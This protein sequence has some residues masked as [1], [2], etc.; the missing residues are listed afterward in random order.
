MSTEMKK[1]AILNIEKKV[2]HLYAEVQIDSQKEVIQTEVSDNLIDSLVYDRID[3]YV[4]GFIYFAMVNGYDIKSDL[5]ITDELLYN[6]NYQFIPAMCAAN[7]GWHIVKIDAPVVE[8]IA[9]V[10]HRVATGISCG[11]DSLYTIKFHESVR[12][13]SS[14]RIDSL[15]FFNVGSSMKSSDVLRTPLVEGRMKLAKKFALEY[16]YDFIF[17]ESNIHLIIHK[18]DEYNHVANHTYMMLFCVYSIMKCISTYY[19]SSGYPFSQFKINAPS[20]AACYDLL[21]LATAS[22]AHLHFYSSGSHVSRM[23]KTAALVDYTPAKKYLNVCVESDQNCGECFKCVRTMLTLDAMGCLKDF[24][25][26]FDLA[27]YA[28]NR[29]KFLDRMYLSA[30]L[31]KDVYSKEILPLFN[32][33]GIGRVF[34]I[35]VG[36]VLRKLRTLFGKIF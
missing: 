33:F 25:A 17:V 14:R 35:W 28:H 24:D 21:T 29:N 19:Y 2:N 4:W 12:E 22:V 10:L 26:V 18:Y 15:T 11:I 6:L 32:C 7:D 1:I 34:C 20:S 8:P 16:G 27:S 23:E 30:V 13:I 5:P 3:A 36:L 31:Q 9:P